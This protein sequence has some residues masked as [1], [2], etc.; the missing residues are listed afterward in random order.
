MQILFSLDKNG[1]DQLEGPYEANS[2]AWA[3]TMQRKGGI[4][5]KFLEKACCKKIILVVRA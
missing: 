4:E 5:P 1:L 3:F 2:K